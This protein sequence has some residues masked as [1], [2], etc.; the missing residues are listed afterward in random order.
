[1]TMKKTITV[2]VCMVFLAG[3]GGS[4]KN[5]REERTAHELADAGMTHFANG[6]YKKA[7]AAFENLRDWYPFSDLAELAEL[8]IAD[9]YFQRKQYPEAI[10][11]YESFKSLH[12]RNRAMP[13]VFYRIALSYY[14]QIR[15]VDRDQGSTKLAIES[16]EEL[17][18]RFP[19][20]P[21][22]DVGK[23]I[24]KCR[25]DMAENIFYIGSHYFKAKRYE[26]AMVRFQSILDDY[27]DI[28]PTLGKAR[29]F[30]NVS[31]SL[32]KERD[33]E[34]ALKKKEEK[35][36]VKGSSGS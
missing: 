30:I 26:A 27:K 29:H 6:D 36:K 31:K 8:K 7:I 19:D 11:E 24:R 35:E 16:F 22:R 23:Y 14:R 13:H 34:E 2:L 33:A 25:S 15:T 17:N 3:C 9:S 1:M 32:I 10:A 5:T 20:H 28:L 18:R 12:P 21:Y 4:L